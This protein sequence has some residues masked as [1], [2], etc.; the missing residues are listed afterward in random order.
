MRERISLQ[1]L[2][3]Y[4]N[5]PKAKALIKQYG[6]EPARNHND[7]VDKLIQMTRDYKEEAL[8]DL[9]LLHPHRDLIM[10]YSKRPLVQP[11][12]PN[13]SLLN[14]NGHGAGC[15]CP[16]CVRDT[17]SNFDLEEYIDFIGSKSKNKSE[18]NTLNEYIPIIAVAGLFAL[19]ITVIG[20]N[21]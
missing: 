8:E 21:I 7:L 9:A 2:V 11:M 16:K 1:E 12:R 13:T 6:Y 3:A 18:K 20:K 4:N 5:T 10:N 15:K 14:E 19:T 17:F